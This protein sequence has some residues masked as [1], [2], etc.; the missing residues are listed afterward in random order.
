MGSPMRTRGGEQ[1]MICPPLVVKDFPF[2]SVSDA[3]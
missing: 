3:V 1:G 2:T